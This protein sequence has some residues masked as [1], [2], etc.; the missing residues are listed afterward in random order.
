MPLEGVWPGRDALMDKAKNSTAML[1]GDV[2]LL[3]L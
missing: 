1:H 2:E 3:D